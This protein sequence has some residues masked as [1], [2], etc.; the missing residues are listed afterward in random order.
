MNELQKIKITD[1]RIRIIRIKS[2]HVTEILIVL[3]III[4]TRK[5]NIQFMISIA[6]FKH[7]ILIN[8]FEINH[9]KMKMLILIVINL[10]HTLSLFRSIFYI[11]LKIFITTILNISR[12]SIYLINVRNNRFFSFICKESLISQT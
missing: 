10:R 11:N 12:T 8:S 6:M 3:Q 1:S 7:F 4:T 5:K 2:R 9:I